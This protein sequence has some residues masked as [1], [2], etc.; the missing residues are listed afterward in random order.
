MLFIIF[1][2][3]FGCSSDQKLIRYTNNYS[4]NTEPKRI[5][6]V[7]I[8]K[9]FT[10]TDK[11]LAAQAI[12]QWNYV[13]NGQI[14]L[15]I[16]DYN[17]DMEPNT[18]IDIKN[19]GDFVILKIDSNNPMIKDQ[20][21]TNLCEQTLAWTDRFGG[22]T[23]YIIRDRI[24]S[25]KLDFVILHE[26]GHLFYLHH[27]PNPKSLMYKYTQF[28]YN[29]CIDYDSAYKVAINYNL[30]FATMNYCQYE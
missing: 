27:V 28:N 8:D 10:I 19:H 1:I 13:L 2:L 11:Q 26:I 16:K 21:D 15:N 30:N 23:I 5:I 17:F 7:Y 22:T 25:T 9:E 24:L 14:I 20:C 12:Y 4:S 18:L 29:T 3:L 6:Q